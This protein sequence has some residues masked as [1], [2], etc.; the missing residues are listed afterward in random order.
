VVTWD[1]MEVSCVSFD[2]AKEF[3]TRL[4]QWYE[5]IK[6]FPVPNEVA[7]LTE[8]RFDGV[9][10]VIRSFGWPPAREDGSGWQRKKCLKE[11][12]RMVDELR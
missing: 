7:F 2:S 6:L 5:E 4:R 8:D 3:F 9:K 10:D 11:V 12:E 1:V